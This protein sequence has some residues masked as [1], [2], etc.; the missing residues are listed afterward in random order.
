MRF[1]HKPRWATTTG[2]VAALMSGTIMGLTWVIQ[3]HL[4]GL[5]V[6][7]PAE[8][9]WLNIVGVALI[10]WP[11]AILRAKGRIVP[12]GT[13]VKWLVLFACTAACIFYFRNVGVGLCGATTAALV[14][15][16]ELVLIFVLTYLVLKQRVAPWGWI[17]AALLVAG[18][19]RVAGLGAEN[20][21]FNA[22]GI[23]ALVLAAMG[24]ASNA[25]IIKTHFGKVAN[26]LVILFSATIQ[27]ALYSLI[28]P[29]FVGM[30]GVLA[31]LRDPRMLGLAALGAVCI[32]GNLFTYYYAMK[33]APMW[34]V[35]I[36][37]LTGPPVA[38]LADHFILGSPVTVAGVQG[39][40][41]V[42][43]GATVVIL[44]ARGDN[45]GQQA[46]PAV[47]ENA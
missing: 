26:E 30:D 5:E 8:L 7:G 46:I 29:I 19:F 44:S 24:I 14:N 23:G 34:I 2:Y 3:S 43:I 31:V 22:V 36:L 37:A 20:L 16:V 27:T 40:V 12:E 42:M 6:I 18:V 39:L 10:I 32:A 17:G 21:E 1:D 13:P 41:A 35:R 47:D 4:L 25:L 45:G 15:R 33:R 11:V 38:M 28:V 9:N